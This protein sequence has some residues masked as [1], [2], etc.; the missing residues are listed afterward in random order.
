MAAARMPSRA[1]V[2]EDDSAG[3]AAAGE[4]AAGEATADACPRAVRQ[5]APE[6][7]EDAVI[8]AA[9]DADGRSSCQYINLRMD[10]Q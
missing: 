9:L 7:T 10:E 6:G 4:G 8:V 1:H 5:E 3:E 2:R